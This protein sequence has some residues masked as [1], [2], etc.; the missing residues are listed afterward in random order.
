MIRYYACIS[1]HD[2]TTVEHITNIKQPTDVPDSTQLCDPLWYDQAKM[3][4]YGEFI[5][6]NDM[7][8]ICNAQQVSL[9][10]NVHVSFSLNKLQNL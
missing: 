4:T 9:L 3:S 2:L 8:L 7:D 6:K 5:I 1:F 10:Q